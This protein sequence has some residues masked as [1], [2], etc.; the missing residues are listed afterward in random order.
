MRKG[1]STRLESIVIIWLLICSCH[2]QNTEQSNS[3]IQ[4]RLN[5]R[6]IS[7][8]NEWLIEGASIMDTQY[9]DE[10]YNLLLFPEDLC[11]LEIRKDLDLVPAYSLELG[12]WEVKENGII[13]VKTSNEHLLIKEVENEG[14]KKAIIN[15]KRFSIDEEYIN[16][17]S[18]KE[19]LVGI[20]SMIEGDWYSEAYNGCFYDLMAISFLEKKT[21][22]TLASG[23][24]VG[25]Y[26]L[27]YFIDDLGFAISED[28]K[29]FKMEFFAEDMEK[30]VGKISL[31]FSDKFEN[32]IVCDFYRQ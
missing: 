9:F 11:L 16:K 13:E 22:L 8:H 20:Q 31:K 30:D 4:D 29:V 25:M 19:G 3:N 1:K 14:R 7:W 10:Y 18:V 32:L 21:N 2:I 23:D 17:E 28:N 5:F 12:E 24:N 15:G 6:L 26:E 27:K